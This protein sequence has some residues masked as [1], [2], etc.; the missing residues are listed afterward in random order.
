MDRP[1][2]DKPTRRRLRPEARR[3]EIVEAAERLLQARG[4]QV[5]VEDVA[6]EA[7]VAKGTVF[8]YFPTWDDLLEAIRDRLIA[9]F[10]A[11][12]PLP[13]EVERPVDWPQLIGRQAAAFVDHALA[14][15]GV[16][17]VIFHSDFARRRPQVDHATVRFAAAIRAGQEAGAFAAVDPEPMARLLFAA[18]HEAADAVAGGAERQATV[19][20]LQ[21]LLRRA[22][23]P[24]TP[25]E[26]APANAP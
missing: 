9:R 21:H 19:G 7:G 8:L 22:L 6:R 17:E 1:L 13:N 16:G 20:A 24:E 18:I 15:Q 26:K 3:L 25:P 5:R 23:A 10:D 12:N 2:I 14:H 4:V 11:A